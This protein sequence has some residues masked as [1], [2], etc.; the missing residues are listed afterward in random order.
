[1]FKSRIHRPTVTDSDLQ[2]VGSLTIGGSDRSAVRVLTIED[3]FS[4]CV[5]FS[6]YERTGRRPVP[7]YDGGSSHS[8]ARCVSMYSL[9]SLL[10]ED[11]SALSN[12]RMPE[13]GLTAS[14]EEGGRRQCSQ[15]G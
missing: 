12:L 13:C 10:P 11:V 7:I 9:Y 14:I 6:L 8:G 5:G 4:Q 2:Y 1:M 3:Q 15:S